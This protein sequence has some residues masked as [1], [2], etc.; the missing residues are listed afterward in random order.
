LE[1]LGQMGRAPFPWRR[2]MAHPCMSR[3]FNPIYVSPVR[4]LP[5]NITLLKIRFIRV[6]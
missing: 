4:F 6:W 1:N 5:S 2:P 3:D